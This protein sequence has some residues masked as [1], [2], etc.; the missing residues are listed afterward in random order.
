MRLPFGQYQMDGSR[1]KELAKGSIPKK[2]AR[3]DTSGFLSEFLNPVWLLTVAPALTPH[4][5]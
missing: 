1:K 2:D 3:T 4:L 5:F